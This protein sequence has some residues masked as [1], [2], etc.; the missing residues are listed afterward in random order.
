MNICVT[1]AAGFIGSHLVRRL[2]NEGHDVTGIDN[3]NRY[4]D[5][6]LK[7]DRLKQLKDSRFVFY[8]LDI[9]NYSKMRKIFVKRQFDYVV[10]LAAQAGVRFSLEKPFLFQKSNNEGFLN[11]LELMREFKVKHFVFASSSSVYGNNEKIPFSENDLVVSPVSLYAATKRSN[12]LM[13]AV[14]AALYKL[15][16]SGVRFFTV[17]G[18]WGRPDMALSK[19]TKSILAREPIDIYNQGNLVRNFTYIDDIVDGTIKVMQTIPADSSRTELYNIGNE[20]PETLMDFIHTLESILNIKVKKNYLPMQSGDVLK[21]IADITK[22]KK[23]GYKPRTGIQEGIGH[24]V[25]WYKKY[26]K[27]DN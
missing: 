6:S 20:H 5:R 16:I 27:K 12:E 11:V 7:M 14:Y 15:P 2:L 25:S 3:L 1:G 9:C 24:F 17:Y 13:A 4:F 8:K 21:T 18:P 26:Y 10:H 23:L 22:I 19:F